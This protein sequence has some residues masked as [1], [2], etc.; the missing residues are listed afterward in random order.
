MTHKHD[1]RI[2]KRC[3]LKT[4]KEAVFDTIGAPANNAVMS[5]ECCA[6]ITLTRR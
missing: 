6:D 2:T 3:K 1:T 5:G 4:A